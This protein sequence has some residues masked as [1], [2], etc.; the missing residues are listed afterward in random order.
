MGEN[1]EVVLLG[2]K[3]PG[4]AP[5]DGVGAVAM[6]S[7]RKKSAG[8]GGVTDRFVTERIVGSGV[9]SGVIS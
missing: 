6:S 7:R 9:E 3:M 5:L 1:P 2:V 4:A 8:C